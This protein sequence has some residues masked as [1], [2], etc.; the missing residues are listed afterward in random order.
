MSSSGEK[1]P[2]A[3]G[4]RPHFVKAEPGKGSKGQRC[5]GYKKP[6]IKQ[7][8]FEGHCEE[9]KHYI[10][11]CSDTHQANM[12]IKTTKEI[13]KYTYK[14]PQCRHWATTKQCKVSFCGDDWLTVSTSATDGDTTDGSFKG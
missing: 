7:P 5:T 1:A 12:Y 9:L 2:P 8:K 11:D 13:A 10:Y 14:Q 4:G 6:V 3:A